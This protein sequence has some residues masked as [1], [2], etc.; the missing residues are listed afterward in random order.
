[1]D[2]QIQ[3]DPV[4]YIVIRILYLFYLF[5]NLSYFPSVVDKGLNQ[6]FFQQTQP[7]REIN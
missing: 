1:M 2:Y 4:D 7:L 5:G 6:K 3:Q